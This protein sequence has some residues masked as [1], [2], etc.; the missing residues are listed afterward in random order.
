MVRRSSIM[1]TPVLMRHPTIRYHH[2]TLG[3]PPSTP[4]CNFKKEHHM[5]SQRNSKKPEMDPLRRHGSRGDDQLPYM[6]TLDADTCAVSA[7]KDTHRSRALLVINERLTQQTCVGIAVLSSGA[8]HTC[9]GNT[10]RDGIL[11]SIPMLN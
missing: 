2:P 10:S 1:D 5:T 8:A 9:S 3:S 4:L 6:G 7:V 11:I